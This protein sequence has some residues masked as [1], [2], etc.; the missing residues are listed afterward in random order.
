MKEAE[1]YLCDLESRYSGGRTPVTRRRVSPLDPRLSPGQGVKSIP[2]N[3]VSGG[4]FIPN[5]FYAQTYVQKLSDYVDRPFV[6]VELGVLLGVGLA[7]WCDVFPE[8]RIVGFDIDP[9]RFDKSLL[10][11]RG[12]FASN[13]PE[14]QFLDELADDASD[15]ISAALG[16]ARI[17]VMI[18]DALH[19]D[20]SILKAMATF[21]PF[22]AE[23]FLY[24]V[25]DN[26][27]VDVAIRNTYPDLNVERRG[28][29]TVV[30]N[31]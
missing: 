31:G 6:L 5:R 13:N 29:L 23:Q 22:M 4:R 25:E 16:G 1:K 19:D 3:M 12:A 15:R 28:K 7:V 26:A 9:D 27:T 8:A 20:T 10:T 2:G 11:S 18:D 14:V 21:M 30:S 24:F 17:D